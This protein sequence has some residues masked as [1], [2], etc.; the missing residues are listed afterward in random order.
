M[1]VSPARLW[2]T[3]LG[4][5][6]AISACGGS[7]QPTASYDALPSAASDSA[8]AQSDLLYVSNSDADVTVYRFWKRDFAFR[9]GGFARPM[10]S[11]ADSMGDV[12]ITDARYGEVVEYKHGGVKPI[13]VLSEVGPPIAC[14]LDERTGDLAVANWEVGVDVYKGGRGKPTLYTDRHLGNYGSLAYDNAGNLFVTN[15]CAYARCSPVSFAYLPSNGTRLR[16]VQMPMQYRRVAGLQWDGK[17]WLVDGATSSGTT[18]LDRFSITRL[19]AGFVGSTQ[20][21]DGGGGPVCLYN[22]TQRGQAS[23]VLGSADYKESEGIF[24]WPYPHGG[25]FIDDIS[26]DVAKPVGCSVSLKIAQ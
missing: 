26:R 18:S 15:G 5:V 2:V 11:C 12:Y 25:P 10:G 7:R 20:L 4:A 24:Y 16:T 3:C 1:G 22:N 9:L 17:Y 19:R 21:T 13:K 23:Y 8:P 6:F 14:A